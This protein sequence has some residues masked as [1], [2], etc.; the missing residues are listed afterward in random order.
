[1]AGV[2]RNGTTLIHGDFLS[3][4]GSCIHAA[5]QRRLA[6]MP[7]PV[8]LADPR[9][10]TYA[11]VA[12]GPAPVAENAIRFIRL[13]SQSGRFPQAGATCKADDTSSP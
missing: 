6:A 2:T 9:S 1:V 13:T 5:L 10:F 3:G 4:G 8:H 7:V 11:G 12:F